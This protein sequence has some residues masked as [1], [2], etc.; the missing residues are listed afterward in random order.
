M[1][2]DYACVFV[3]LG[4]KFTV[5]GRDAAKA[6]AFAA[7]F[8]SSGLVAAV[9]GGGVDAA[10]ARLADK[11]MAP[12]LHAVVAAP[13]DALAPIAQQLAA[14]CPSILLEK[15]GALEASEVRALMDNPAVRSGACRISIGYNRRF[16]DSIAYVRGEIAESGPALSAILE[17]D[18]PIPRIEALPTPAAIKARWGYANASHVFD[19]LFH[20]CGQSIAHHAPPAP[21]SDPHLPWH[22]AGSVYVGTGL[23]SSGTRYIYH[24]NYAS[25][26]RWRLA[27]SLRQRR[28]MLMP[29]EGVQVVEG[30]SVALVDVAL[31]ADGS[32]LKPGLKGQ[33]EAFLAGDPQGLIASLSYQAWHMDHLAT[34]FGYPR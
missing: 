20:L 23:T 24:G 19:L 16:L 31:P 34:V 27:L 32:G 2:R 7:E 9:Y 28:L 22:P 17:F 29:L 25:V 30:A 14:H 12:P 8:R 4:L 3:A 15:P 26:G 33:V 21:A 10:L 11:A 18:E 13:V 1:A 5:I 6:E